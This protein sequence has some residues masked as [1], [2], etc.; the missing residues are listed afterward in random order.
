MS[1][2]SVRS[3]VLAVMASILVGGSAVAQVFEYDAASGAIAFPGVVEQMRSDPADRI[4]VTMPD[5]TVRQFQPPWISA[6]IARA[7]QHVRMLLAEAKAQG[8]QVSVVLLPV[9]RPIRWSWNSVPELVRIGSDRR[10]AP[11]RAMLGTSDLRGVG[12]SRTRIAAADAAVRSM[13]AQAVSKAVIGTVKGTYGDVPVLVVERPAGSSPSGGAARLLQEALSPNSSLIAAGGT[14]ANLRAAAAK[15]VAAFRS[16]SAVA[17]ADYASSATTGQL[18]G[19]SANAASGGMHAASARVL[20]TQSGAAWS[21]SNPDGEVLA[22]LWVPGTPALHGDTATRLQPSVRVTPAPGGIRIV[23]SYSNRTDRTCELASMRLPSFRLGTSIRMQDTRDLGGTIPMSPSSPVWRGT[24]P[25]ILYAPACIM[26]NDSVAVGVSVEYPVLEYK[27]DIRLRCTSTSQGEWTPE[28]GLE[29]STAH[30]GFSH[31]RTCPALKPG[32]SRVYCV[33]IGIAASNDW[34]A[35]LSPYR[36]FFQATYG[37]ASYVRDGRP[38]AGIALSQL[39]SMSPDNPSGWVPGIGMLERDGFS[40]AASMLESRFANCSDRVMIWAPTGYSSNHA[41]NYP[42]QFASRWNSGQSGTQA[43]YRDAPAKLRALLAGNPGPRRLGLWWGHS[44]N[45]SYAWGESPVRALDSSDHAMKEVWFR[46][47][48]EAVGSGATEIGLDAFAHDRAP[49][50]ELAAYLREAK[51][52]FPNLRFCIEPRTCDFLHVLAPTW[53]DGY[54]S[55]PLFGLPVNVVSERFAIA[56]YLIPGQETWVG[57]QFN[58]SRDP[59]LWGSGSSHE[60]Q[61]QAVANIGSLGYVPVTWVPMWL[62]SPTET[63]VVE[64]AAQ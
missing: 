35:T 28:L 43:G 56:D 22:P 25:G 5:R 64:G 15:S 54:R 16:R 12:S 21:A 45:P 39:E 46:E 55:T 10:S 42:F 19:A 57:L 47:L 44:A 59:R 62:K 51:A 20:W 9:E 1:R 33:N 32:E 41:A 60:A 36:T 23:F 53:I 2:V 26:R 29:N 40:N 13:V 50:W 24:Y 52:R 3:T 37:P 7:S 27:H 34:L 17:S 63:F 6:G 11:L 48:A 58:L 61:R 14:A 31:L 18:A 49:V 8:K 38:V 4:S 30:C